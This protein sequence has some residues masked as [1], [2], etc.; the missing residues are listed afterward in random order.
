MASTDEMGITVR[1]QSE[2]VVGR[3]RFGEKGITCGGRSYRNR[4][5]SQGEGDI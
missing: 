4:C 1:D 5:R 2:I 3:K